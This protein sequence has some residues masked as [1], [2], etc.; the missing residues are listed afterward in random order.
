MSIV[1]ELSAI[2]RIVGLLDVDS[3]VEIGAMVH[4]RNTDFN[5]ADRETPADGVITGYGTIEGKL[6][7]IYSQDVNVLQG[8]VGEMHAKKI[9]RL[10]DMALKMGSPVIGLIDCAGM[11]LQEASDALNAFGELYRK[12]AMASGVIPQIHGIFG[13]CGGGMAVMTALADFTFAVKGQGE[14]FV[15]SPNVLE[16][17]HRDRCDTASSV[18][19][20]EMTGLLDDVGEDERDVLDKIRRLVGILPSNNKEDA[21]GMTE[22]ADDLNRENPS[23]GSTLDSRYI[24]EDISDNHEFFE[25]KKNYGREM[26]IGFISLNGNTVG[27]VAN[28]EEVLGEAGEVTGK[29]EPVLTTEGGEKAAGFIRFCDAFSIPVLTLVNVRGFK[30]TVAEEKRIAGVCAKLTY[31]YASATVPKVS[32]IIGKAY[33]SAYLSMGSGHIGADMVYAWPTARIGMMDSESA[34][35]IIYDDEI[36]QSENK[37]EFIAEKREIYDR[38]QNSPESAASRGYV[39]GIIEPGTTRKRVIAAFEMLMTKRETEPDRKHGTV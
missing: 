28:R 22:N 6:V 24:L 21:V 18:Y 17:N 35:K 15:H 27:A 39:D 1:I 29:M 36:G 19:Q 25:I 2:D 16:G 20:S 37:N 26:V 8:S 32:V 11:R 12:Q 14:L 30:A 5:M 38:L 4:A 23:L 31:A 34:V 7:Y 9:V 13:K 3:F 10:Y 33:G